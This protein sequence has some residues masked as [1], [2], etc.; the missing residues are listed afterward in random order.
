MTTANLPVRGWSTQEWL[1]F[2]NSL[3]ADLPRDKAAGLD[4]TFALSKS[5]NAE[6]AMAWF[7]IAIRADY[8]P[9]YPD[10]QRYLLTIG[11]RKL[12]RP[13][14]EELMKSPKGASLARA[15]YTQARPGYHP[16]TAT[17]IDLIVNPKKN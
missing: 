16:I 7:Q 12:V 11:R 1:Q 8:D 13:L 2:L 5:R 4:E 9:A 17:A 14:Y 15:T 3:P 6:I 10:L